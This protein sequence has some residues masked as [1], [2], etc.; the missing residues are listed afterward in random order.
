VSASISAPRRTRELLQN[1]EVLGRPRLEE[2]RLAELREHGRRVYALSRSF[3]TWVR[4]ARP[5][6]PVRPTLLRLARQP[7][8]EPLG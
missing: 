6:A 7:E 5:D 3:N 2:A 8:A 4:L 1:L